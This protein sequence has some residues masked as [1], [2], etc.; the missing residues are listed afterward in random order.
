MKIF[1]FF[2][3]AVF[4]YLQYSLWIGKNGIK[5]FFKI[6]ESIRIQE[7]IKSIKE[8]RVFFYKKN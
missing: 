3:V 1:N 7:F 4:F 6:K 5:D 8:N 2:L